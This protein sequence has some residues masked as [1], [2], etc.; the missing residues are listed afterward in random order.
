MVKGSSDDFGLGAEKVYTVLEIAQMFNS[1]IIMLP[2]R[3]GN[4]QS[5]YLDTTKSNALGWRAKKDVA[6]YIEEIVKTRKTK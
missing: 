1:E 3:Q 6:D 5:A 2:E 4:R